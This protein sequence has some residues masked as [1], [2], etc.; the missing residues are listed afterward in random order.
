MSEKEKAE[1]QFPLVFDKCPACGWKETVARKVKDEEVEK[2][3]IKTDI[4][5]AMAQSMT[6]IVDQRTIL[7]L[8]SVPILVGFYDVCLACGCYYCVRVEKASGVVGPGAPGGPQPRPGP[9][10]FFP[11]P[12]KGPGLKGLGPD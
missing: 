8:L 12:F 5:A 9:G 2:G 10:G 3:R 7:A 1:I 4:T 11:P 6:P